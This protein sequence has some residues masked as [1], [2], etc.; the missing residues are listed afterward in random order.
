MNNE[1]TFEAWINPLAFLEVN[2]PWASHDKKT[3]D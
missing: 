2:E 3:I 1:K